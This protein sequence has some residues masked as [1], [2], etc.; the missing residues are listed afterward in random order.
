MR[1]DGKFRWLFIA[2][3]SRNSRPVHRRYCSLD[4]AVIA[5]KGEYIPKLFNTVSAK[6]EDIDY[7]TKDGKTY[8]YKKIYDFD[9]LLIRLEPGE[10]RYRLSPYRKAVF[11]N[12]CPNRCVSFERSED[13]VL[14]LDFMSYSLDGVKWLPADE[15]RRIE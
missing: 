15:M 13:K 6:T 7:E 8:I 10:G 2:H 12:G 9:S 14:V 11:A 4:D 3:S 5:V 1:E